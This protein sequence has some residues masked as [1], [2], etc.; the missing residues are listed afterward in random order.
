MHG[1]DHNIIQFNSFERLMNI[2]RRMRRKLRAVDSKTVAEAA[3]TWL[4]TRPL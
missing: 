4:R 1:I 3:L 2:A